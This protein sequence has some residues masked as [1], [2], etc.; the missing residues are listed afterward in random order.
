MLKRVQYSES[1]NHMIGN[2]D[3]L[4]EL[5]D[6]S[7][8]HSASFELWCHSRRFIAS[9][10]DKDG[11]ILDI[12]CGNG[13][14]LRSFQEWSG[15]VLTPYGIDLNQTF[16][17]QAKSLFPQQQEHF[18]QFD[19]LKLPETNSFILPRSYDFVYWA[20]WDNWTF[21]RPIEIS[22]IRS[23]APMVKS[24]GKLIVGLYHG[25]RSKGYAVLTRLESLGFS[26]PNVVENF[27][28]CEVVA[29]QEVSSSFATA[30]AP[31]NGSDT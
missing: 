9:A 7:C 25:D 21:K 18:L 19:I 13:F 27:D 24:G 3:K 31:Q 8:F 28:G 30:P 12:G 29:W 10:I 16:I 23:I 11:T 2:Q 20:I 1:F 15:H 6:G 26:F 4:T 17:D 22:V 14:L 5:L